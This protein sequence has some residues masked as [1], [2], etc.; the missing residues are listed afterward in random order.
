MYVAMIEE[1]LLEKCAT[2]GL[3][4]GQGRLDKGLLALAFHLPLS[5]LPAF[6]EDS[7]HIFTFESSLPEYINLLGK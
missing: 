3:F 4:P 1:V 5:D 6:F 2:E 7:I